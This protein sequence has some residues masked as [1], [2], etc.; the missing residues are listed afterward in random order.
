MIWLSPYGVHINSKY[1]PEPE[2][3]DPDRFLKTETATKRHPFAY[4]PF[5][6]KSRAWYVEF[7]AHEIFNA[8]SATLNTVNMKCSTIMLVFEYSNF[9]RI[10]QVTV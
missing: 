6:M 10:C 7:F 5:G 4:L 1:W 2:K 3:F 9:G 8:G